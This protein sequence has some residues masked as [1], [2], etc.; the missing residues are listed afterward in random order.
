MKKRNKRNVS[1]ESYWK[2]ATDI[3]AGVLL[4]IMLV[5]MLLLLYLTQVEKEKADNKK[6]DYIGYGIDDLGDT[7]ENSTEHNDHNYDGI[8]TDPPHDYDDGGGGGGGEDDPGTENPVKINPDDGHDKTAVFVTV[9]DEE[10]GNVI[11][12]DGTLFELYA[13]KNG[14]GGLQTLHTYYPEKVEYKQYKTTQNGTFYLPE[15]ITRGWYSL[16]NLVPPQGYGA[17]KNFDFEVTE[18]LDWP[19]PYLVKIPL[20]PS[21]NHI[22]VR[23]VDTD[24]KVQIPEVIYDVYAAEDIIT[25]DG[26]LRYSKDQKVDEIK[27]DK[28]GA[29]ASKKLYLGKYYLMQK[30]I[31][32]F[33][34]RV[35]TPV[36]AEI[37]LTDTDQNAV[38]VSCQKTQI[39]VTLKDEFDDTPIV[40]ATY[41]VSGRDLVKTDQNGKIVITDLE[42]DKE[43]KVNLTEIPEPYRTKASALSFLVDK[44][45]NISGEPQVSVDQ[46]VYQIRI[47]IDVTDQIFKNSVTGFTFKLFDEN[48]EVVDD[49]DAVGADHPIEGLEPGV[50]YLETN[51]DSSSKTKI[52]VKDNGGVQKFSKRVWTMWDTVLVITAV[53]AAA[54]I[55]F[56]AIRVIRYVRRKKPNEPQ[57]KPVEKK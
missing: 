15:K 47:S 34:A 2:S 42:K 52:N 40:G 12:K 48:D 31:A 56:V 49:W 54:L 36:Q 37:K 16:H 28:A 33:Y 30:T 9:V 5:L 24:T 50:Y 6:S 19:E 29:G 38:I 51:G 20:S 44:D 26:T 45:G 13:D 4:V 35:T 21:K 27:C 7:Y 53:V 14:A 57:K 22:Y 43:Y 17:A 41:A 18:P 39:S 55:M 25:L 1:E 23:T 8:Y 3:M 11:K 32:P 46:S 10:T